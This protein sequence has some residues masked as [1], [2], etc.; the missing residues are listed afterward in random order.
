M[1]FC[2]LEK[3][4]MII[5]VSGLGPGMIVRINLLSD[6]GCEMEEKKSAIFSLP[7]HNHRLIKDNELIRKPVIDPQKKGSSFPVGAYREG[8][9]G[10]RTGDLQDIAVSSADRKKVRSYRV[11]SL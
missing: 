2:A 10:N 3:G 9:G 5:I 11:W 1:A 8:T 7:F 6:D 4:R